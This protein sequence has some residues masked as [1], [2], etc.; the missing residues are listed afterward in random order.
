[1]QSKVEYL[2]HA[3]DDLGVVNAARVSHGDEH[4][5]FDDVADAGLIRFLARG[6]TQSE[7]DKLYGDI[8]H[9]KRRDYVID[10]LRQWRSTPVHKSP[11][12]HVWAKF[13]VHMPIFVARQLVKHEYLPWNERSG[14]YETL[15]WVPRFYW[16]EDNDWRY[17]AENVKQGSG[18]PMDPETVEDLK[19]HY[20]LLLDSAEM[21]YNFA[22]GRG[23]CAEQAR[24]GLPQSLMTTVVWSG[25]L[26]A[27]VNMCKLRMDPHTQAESRVIAEQIH[28][29]LER[30]FPVSTAALMSQ[31]V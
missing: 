24:M 19:E 8:K 11:F 2:D 12:N 31:G 29:H 15:E 18:G 3:G 16:P 4:G 20:D 17:E 7:F 13:R 22:R 6:M 9:D 30:L 25:T 26:H 28:G 1:M 23:L 14:R 27:F 5:E 21:W 10:Y